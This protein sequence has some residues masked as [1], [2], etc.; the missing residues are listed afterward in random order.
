MIIALY[1]FIKTNLIPELSA[2]ADAMLEPI[3]TIVIAL[4]GMVMLFG[5][6][7]MRISENMGSTILSA[8]FS[9][10]GFICRTIIS[11]IGWII[12]N[13][14]ALLPRVY[15]GSKHLYNDMGASDT[16]STLLGILTAVVTLIVII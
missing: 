6:V 3:M 9:A 12:R 7:G 16:V 2:Y 11:A 5:A 10:L 15:R 8:I 1:F 4:F 13:T 14:F